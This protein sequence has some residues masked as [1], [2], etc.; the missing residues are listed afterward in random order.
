MEGRHGLAHSSIIMRTDLLKSVGGYWKL[1]L[2]DDWDMM[3]RMGERAKLAN[4]PEVLLNYRVH[5]GS[6]NGQSMMRMHRHISFA[7]DRAKRRQTG[8][9]EISFE[10]FQSQKQESP[11]TSRILEAVHVYALTQY[12]I[13]LAEIYGGKKWMGQARL[14]W[15]AICSPART[16]GRI[17]RA[18]DAKSRSRKNQTLTKPV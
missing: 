17:K 2:I 14:V 11:L 13:A 16:I 3:L 15:S 8:Q 5:S 10:E 1:K 9:Q 12:R 7:I 6:L 4:L 18:L